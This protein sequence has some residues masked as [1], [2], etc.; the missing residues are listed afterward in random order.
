VTGLEDYPDATMWEPRPYHYRSNVDEK[1]GRSYVEQEKT[2]LRTYCN[3]GD[4]PHFIWVFALV[5]PIPGFPTGT[6]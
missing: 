6:N 3:T 2:F 4:G 5:L 1:D